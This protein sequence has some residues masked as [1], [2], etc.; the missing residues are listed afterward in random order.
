MGV[1]GELTAQPPATTA[2]QLPAWRDADEQLLAR[3]TDE[4]AVQQLWRS[5][6][7]SKAAP[8]PARAAVLARAA[9]GLAGGSEAVEQAARGDAHALGRLLRGPLQGWSAPLLHA[10]ATYFARLAE[11]FEHDHAPQL[12]ARVRSLAAWVALAEERTFLI[13]LARR[14]AGVSDAAL[15]TDALLVA[16]RTL[17]DWGRIAVQGAKRLDARSGAAVAALARASDACRLAGVPAT[18]GERYFKKA[19]RVR[20]QAVDEALASLEDAVIEARAQGVRAADAA[21]HF[22]H[23]RRVWVWA[24]HDEAVER[25]AVEQVTPLAWDIQQKSDWSELRVLLAPCEPLFDRFEQR[26]L[27]RPH[28]IAYAAKCA[29]ILVF[30]SEAELDRNKEWLLA[31]RAVKVCP[32]HRNGRLILAYLLSDRA[33]VTLDRSTIFSARADLAAANEL[34]TRAEALF[35]QGQRTKDARAKLDAAKL[36]WGAPPA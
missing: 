9:R 17:E 22:E 4:L 1:A 33:I 20:A 31:E 16:E 12:E 21:V 24:D 8:L 25:F 15:E 6:A 19:E 10:A 32:V 29:Q 3:L 7:P 27:A 30:R 35:P 28:D 14:V 34:V 36:R 2:E 11:T 26:L 18:R 13:E 23:I 5:D